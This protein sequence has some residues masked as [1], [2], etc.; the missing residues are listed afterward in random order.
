[1]WITHGGVEKKTWK[2]FLI[3]N[4]FILIYLSTVAWRLCFNDLVICL[5]KTDEN[6]KTRENIKVDALK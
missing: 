5:I 1:M 6:E 3:A 2:P 4:W